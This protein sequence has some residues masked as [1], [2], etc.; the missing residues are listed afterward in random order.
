MKSPCRVLADRKKRKREEAIRALNGALGA[1]GV[2]TDEKEFMLRHLQ[3]NGFRVVKIRRS[4]G[5]TGIEQ[6]EPLGKR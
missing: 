2:V 3:R 1:A 6:H 4:S 5:N